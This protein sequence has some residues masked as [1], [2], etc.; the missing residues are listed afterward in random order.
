[1]REVMG[2]PIVYRPAV[3]YYIVLTP[4]HR[5]LNIPHIPRKPVLCIRKNGSVYALSLSTL[6]IHV[7]EF[8]LRW[9]ELADPRSRLKLQRWVRALQDQLL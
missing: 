4:A 9:H 7:D 5:R 2:Y 8:E 1:M 3:F 6:L